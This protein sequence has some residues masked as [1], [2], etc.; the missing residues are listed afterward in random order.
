[1]TLLG[2]RA[3]AQE[4][5]EATLGLWSPRANI[6]VAS[7]GNGLPGT[8]IDLRNDAGLTDGHVPA[9]TLAWR[10]AARH[11]IRLEYLPIGY[12]S[13][14]TLLRDVRFTGVTYPKSSDV[15]SMFDWKSYAVGYEY[16][17]LLRSRWSAGV[18]VEARQTDIQERLSSPSAT[19]ARRTR[20]PVPVAG[21]TVRVNPV[22]RLSLAIECT[23]FKVPN[24]ADRHY[25]GH[26][27]DAEVLGTF[28]VTPSPGRARSYRVGVQA[29]YRYVD[30]STWE[31]RTRR[32]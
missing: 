21:G 25:G 20:V 17:F 27:L 14:A 10:V 30:I 9:I 16:D 15:D 6:V 23:G 29:G 3:G 28:D 12:D 5:L 19:Q 31:S 32:R 1:M 26:Y 11:R 18:I 7:D 13:S 24:S 4:R 22:N 2:T 8:S